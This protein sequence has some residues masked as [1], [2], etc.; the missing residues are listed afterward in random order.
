LYIQVAV[1]AIL[2]PRGEVLIARRPEGVHQG[3][4]WEFPG[5]KFEPGE[6]LHD[7]LR[8]EIHEEL[9][10]D[11][12]ALRPL[13]T[14]DHDYGDK[15]VSLRVCA[16]ESFEGE[17]HGREGQPLRWVPVDALSGY[18]FPAAN[19]PIVTALQLP[20]CCLVT[21]DPAG[22][23]RAFLDHLERRL[24]RGDIRL[25]QLRAPSLG[26]DALARLCAR[27]IP[28]ARSLGVRVMLNA[29]PELARAVGADGAHLNARRLAAWRAGTARHGLMLSASVHDRRELMMAR[30]AGVDFALIAPVMPTASH[31]GAPVLG[32]DGFAALAALATMPV[33]ALGGVAP[34]DVAR[35]WACGGQGVAAIRALWE[36]DGL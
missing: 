23:E 32:W 36:A 4:L 31:P 19:L 35:A 5:G 29:D 25:M 24:A 12:G 7:A 11:V 3:G 6:D 15:R 22:D 9:G 26:A 2:N 34:V 10:I 16:V 27:V 33:Y 30:D 21:P 17:P 18:A 1:A 13:I 8:R 14:I 28:M 20:E